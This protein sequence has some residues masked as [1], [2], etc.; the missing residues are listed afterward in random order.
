[1]SFRENISERRSIQSRIL[2]W[3]LDNI[4]L[5]WAIGFIVLLVSLGIGLYFVWRL[6]EMTTGK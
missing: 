1:M 2:D 5:I 3:A 6:V 4:V